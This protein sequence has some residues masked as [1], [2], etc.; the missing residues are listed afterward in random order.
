VLIPATT[1]PGLY[2]LCAKADDAN[3]VAELNDGNNWACTTKTIEVP[4]PDLVVSVFANFT[5]SAPVG[6]TMQVLDST[7][8]QGGSQAL[9]FEVGYVLSPNRKIGDSDDIPLPT[10]RTL[11]SLGVGATST[12]STRLIISRKV[13]PGS[14]WVGAIADVKNTVDELKEG[15]NTKRASNKVTVSP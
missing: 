10:T 14:Y 11:T 1:P 9:N 15:N 5:L 6:G 3:A 8:N 7:K 4:K 2:H 13:A 12:A